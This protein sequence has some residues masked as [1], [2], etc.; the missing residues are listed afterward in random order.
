MASPGVAAGVPQ[1][2]SRARMF[3][4]YSPKTVLGIKDVEDNEDFRVSV[5]DGKAT[6][7]IFFYLALQ[8][9]NPGGGSDPV[10]IAPYIINIKVDYTLKFVEFIVQFN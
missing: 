1:A 2:G 8:G 3:A 9:L 10:G 7:K 5:V 4:T 6:E